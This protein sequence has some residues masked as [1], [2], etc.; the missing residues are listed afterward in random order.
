MEG[1]AVPVTLETLTAA[2]RLPRE[3]LEDPNYNNNSLSRS[4]GLGSERGR[5]HWRNHR[6]SVWKRQA[7]IS[8]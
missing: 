5:R 7:V 6:E 8:G 1:I 4:V 3:A 2:P